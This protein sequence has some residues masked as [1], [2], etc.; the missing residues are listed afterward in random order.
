M[1]SLEENNLTD[2]EEMMFNIDGATYFNMLD[3][4]PYQEA[5][6]EAR[7]EFK[8]ISQARLNTNRS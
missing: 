4:M 2:E 5:A 8:E 3:G 1:P 6:M 7:K